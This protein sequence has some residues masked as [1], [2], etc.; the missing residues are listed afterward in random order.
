MG[1]LSYYLMHKNIPITLISFSETGDIISYANKI[2]NAEHMPIIAQNHD[3]GIYDW[4]NNRAVPKT[5]D[6]LLQMLSAK[7]LSVPQKYLFNNLGLSLTDCYWIKPIDSDL[8][9]EDVSLFS[10]PFKDD[11]LK[12]SKAE[13]NT[14]EYSPNSSLL[15]N[16]EKTWAIKG[17]DRFLIKGNRTKK[18]YESLNEV[19]ATQIHD[20]QK[21]DC[22]RYDLLHIAGKSY[23]YGCI[24]KIF[25]SEKLELVSAYEILLCSSS[26]P[27]SNYDK[28][29]RFCESMGMKKERAILDYDYLILSDYILSQTDRHF[30]NFGFLRDPDTLELL[31]PA[32]IYDSGNSMYFDSIAPKSES[33]LLHL[34][35]KGLASDLEQSLSFVHDASVIDLTKLPSVSDI[36]ELYKKDIETDPNHLEGICYAYEKRIDR[37]RNF[38]L[39]ISQ[40]TPIYFQIPEKDKEL[41][42]AF[43][44]DSQISYWM[45]DFKENLYYLFLQK[46]KNLATLEKQTQ[47]RLDDVFH[48]LI[49]R[50]ENKGFDKKDFVEYIKTMKIIENQTELEYVLKRYFKESLNSKDFEPNIK[51]DPDSDDWT[52]L[53]K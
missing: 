43:I 19:L 8:T 29:I 21:H 44:D 24:T 6:N 18:S 9:W 22:A 38:Q 40:K 25:T 27:G 52:G 34:S 53:G 50:F 26:F 51:D 49:L 7:G 20:L 37:C 16:I 17:N 23:E 30:N 14:P 35:T 12:F 42:N 3:T 48:K 4:W 46:R 10:N 1:E 13:N 11:S 15:G 39:G 33:D 45:R 28:L 5:R 36:K 41:V 32:P 2:I 47:N 31:C